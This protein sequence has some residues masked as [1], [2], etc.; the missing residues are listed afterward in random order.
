M[1]TGD[2]LK[3]DAKRKETMD[4][5]GDES[6]LQWK[7]LHTHH[8]KEKEHYKERAVI[9]I[10][11]FWTGRQMEQSKGINMNTFLNNSNTTTV[12]S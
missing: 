11:L 12:R 3:R 9:D 2:L 1:V 4:K 8:K 7:W 6:G 10:Q 5:Q